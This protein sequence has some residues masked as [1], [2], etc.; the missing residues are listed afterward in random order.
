MGPGAGVVFTG[1]WFGVGPR[2]T[3][4]GRGFTVFGGGRFTLF[5]ER[6]FV[7]FEERSDGGRIAMFGGRLWLDDYWAFCWGC[8][9]FA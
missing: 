8:P 5:D 1:V 7:T 4:D 9:T 2:A 6:R 3:F